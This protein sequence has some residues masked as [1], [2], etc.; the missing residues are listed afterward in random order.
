MPLC[1]VDEFDHPVIG[2]PGRFTKGK[3]PVIDQPQPLRLRIGVG[4]FR[5][6]DR[7]IK[8]RHDVGHNGQPVTIDGLTNCGGVGL[9]D[10][11]QNRSGV[12][13]VDKFGRKETMQKR[14][15]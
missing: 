15:Q 10:Q 7:E 9:I 1:H 12:G 2:L 14:F 5:S 13:M 6:S 3:Q 8:A 11:G 4:D